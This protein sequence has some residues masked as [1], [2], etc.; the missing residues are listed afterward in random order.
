MASRG[1]T[2]QSGTGRP[3]ARAQAM[4]VCSTRGKSRNAAPGTVTIHAPSWSR[5][6]AAKPP[7][8]AD[9][10]NFSC[11]PA[12]E[13]PSMRRSVGASVGAPLGS[14]SPLTSTAPGKSRPSAASSAALSPS[15]MPHSWHTLARS[16]LSDG[17]SRPS[18]QTGIPVP[19]GRGPGARKNASPRRGS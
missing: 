14:A 3:I 4:V 7:S 9:M 8:R 15:R 1:T 5:A 6:G 11:M 2:R 19:G 12:S 18:N 16:A 13:K 10:L 17:G